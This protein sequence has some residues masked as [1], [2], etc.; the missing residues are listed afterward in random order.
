MWKPDPGFFR[1]LFEKF[2]IDPE[3]SIF[4]DD[5]PKNVEAA[6]E[7]GMTG[8]VFTGREAFVKEAEAYIGRF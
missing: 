1:L 2:D 8:I 5:K 6:E 4:T 3:E 7:L